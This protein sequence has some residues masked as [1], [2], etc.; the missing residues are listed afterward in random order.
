MACLFCFSDVNH[1]SIIGSHEVTQVGG[2]SAIYEGIEINIVFG[3]DG[4]GAGGSRLFESIVFTPSE[5]GTTVTVT[6]DDDP[7]FNEVVAIL[8]NGVNDPLVFEAIGHPYGCINGDGG[9]EAGSF[10]GDPSGANGIDF[11]GFTI[12]SIGL[13]MD[14]LTLDI[15][16]DRNWTDFF[17]TYTI[18]IEGEPAVVDSDGDGIPDQTDNCPTLPNPDQLD[19]DGDDTG[20]V[21]DTDDDNDGDPDATDCSP[22]D[23]AIYNGAAEICNGI[24]DNCNGQIDETVLQTFFRDTDGDGF[25]NPSIFI[26]A[27]SPPF[28]YVTDN[29]DC[30]DNYSD[31]NPEANEV[32]NG[33][34]DNCDGQVDEGFIDSD[35]DGQADCIDP[36]DDNDG[37]ADGQDLCP[38]TGSE[39]I[40]DASGCSID[41]L[42]PCEGPSPEET[43]RSHGNY[44][45]CVDKT[46]KQFAK[47]DLI[48]NKEKAILVRQADWSDCGR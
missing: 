45:A 31:I 48:T 43:W 4:T 18:I 41:Q 13:R 23:P 11:Q 5:V 14:A 37:V 21:C 40:V 35:L 8:T 9:S 26:Q 29:T 3:G 22:L 7:E 6:K 42:C 20:D 46:A 12:T 15:Q 19:M 32:C 44:V 28:G 27:C 36:D 30:D 33:L 34:D 39:I 38:N 10:F 16:S 17:T 1:A 47:D 2:C 25:G 24:D